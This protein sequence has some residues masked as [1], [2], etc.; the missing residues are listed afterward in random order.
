[1][2]SVPYGI[3]VEG[4]ID[5]YLLEVRLEAAQQTGEDHQVAGQYASCS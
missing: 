1:M 2:I 3:E 5:K 4:L